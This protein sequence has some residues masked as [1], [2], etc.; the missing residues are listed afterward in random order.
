MK[1]ILTGAERAKLI[2]QGIIQLQPETV[3]EPP[4]MPRKLKTAVQQKHP[5]DSWKF[6][7]QPPHGF[8]RCPDGTFRKKNWLAKHGMPN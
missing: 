2:A 8:L 5:H 1:L 4:L 6:R 7:R 3:D